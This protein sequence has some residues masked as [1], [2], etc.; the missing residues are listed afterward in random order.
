MS[1]KSR[2]IR[3]WRGHIYGHRQHGHFLWKLQ[4]WSVVSG[5]YLGQTGAAGIGSHGSARQYLADF[6]I[7]VSTRGLKSDKLTVQPV[8]P[9]H[10]KAILLL[11]Y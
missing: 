10:K 1:T 9:H 6:A 2:Y 7:V 11:L 8:K 4:W 5:L 3:S